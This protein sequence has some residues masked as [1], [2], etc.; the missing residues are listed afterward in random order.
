M[1]DRKG[2]GLLINKTCKSLK[3]CNPDASIGLTAEQV[4]SRMDAGAVN[5]QGTGL[6]PTIS[7]IISK[8]IFT[9]FN[10]INIFLAIILVIVGHPEN[11]LFLGVAV[12]NTFMGIF[13]ELRAKRG[14]D[15]LSVL[16]KAHVTV[17]RDGVEYSVPQDEI[18][19]DDIIVLD[20][21]NQ[22]CADG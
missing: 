9:L 11:I 14:L 12:S 7:S 10:F 13:Q 18:V 20:M 8:N 2:K 4:R 22:I 16:A 3:R 6:T 21:G 5:V 1:K 19:L 15:K 17:I